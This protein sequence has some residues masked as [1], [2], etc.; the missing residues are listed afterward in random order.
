MPQETDAGVQI[1]QSSLKVLDDDPNWCVMLYT[2]RDCKDSGQNNEYSI[3]VDRGEYANINTSVIPTAWG[4]HFKSYNDCPTTSKLQSVTLYSDINAGR[5][6]LATKRW[7]VCWMYNMI[8]SLKSTAVYI[9][10]SFQK[11]RID[12]IRT[13]TFVVVLPY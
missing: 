6:L 13:V 2:T 4:T 1:R 12:L 8:H 9:S 11:R 3:R 5:V 10:S 7:R